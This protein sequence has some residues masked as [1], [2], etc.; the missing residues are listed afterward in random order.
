MLCTFLFSDPFE[1][2]PTQV[3]KKDNASSSL[4]GMVKA[5]WW[6]IP[7]KTHPK[8]SLFYFTN[9]DFQLNF[10]LYYS[11]LVSSN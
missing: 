8:W 2:N 7:C 4:K 10:F 9:L 3:R 1:G 5:K 11:F 6:N